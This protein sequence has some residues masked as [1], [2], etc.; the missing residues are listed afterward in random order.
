MRALFAICLLLVLVACIPPGEDVAFE[1]VLSTNYSI[2]FAE[3]ES[4]VLRNA[5]EWCDFW[6]SAHSAQSDPPV[7]DLSI[8]DFDYETALAVTMGSQ[9]SGCFSISVE[10]IETG[11]EPT[12]ITVFVQEQVPG[13]GCLCTQA[14]TSPAE[15]VV[16]DNPIGSV[17]FV[18][19]TV[20]LQCE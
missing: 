5:E 19:E 10:S 20:T 3:P 6:A 18:R 12:A 7:C 17:E 16:V 8:V 11:Q 2:D 4:L 14:M 15:A 1:P 13:A 9:I